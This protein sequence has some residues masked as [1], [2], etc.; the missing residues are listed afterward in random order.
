VPLDPVVLSQFRKR[1]HDAV[2][3]ANETWTM[4]RRL[5]L[6]EVAPRTIQQ[7]RAA[8]AQSQMDAGIRESLLSALLPGETAG[9]KGISGDLMRTITGLGATKAVRSLCVLVGLGAEEP[10]PADSSLSP[11]DIEAFLRATM[12]PYDLLLAVDRPSVI[13]FGAGDLMFEEQLVAQYLP[14]IKQTG[15]TLV[16]H[17]MDR[18]D[19]G[20]GS[21][22]VQ[23]EQDRLRR[24][25]QQ[26]S[27]HLRF[28]FSGNEDMFDLLA[29]QTGRRYTIA[30]CHSPASP[31]FAYEPS[32]LASKVID[33][34]LRET[35]G[36]FRRARRGG[37][38]V[39]EVHHGQEWLTFPPWKFD[40]YGPLALLDLLSRS[41]KLCVM[42]A[43]DMEVFLEILS[44]LLPD[45]S[46][47]PPDVFF[48]E[49]NAEKFFG[50]AFAKLSRLAVGERAVLDVIRPA[51]PRV[52]GPAGDRGETYS[53]R[54]VEVRRGA[55]FAEVPAGRTAY[56]F[57][58][59]TREAAPW[60]LTLVPSV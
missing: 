17:A 42:G 19:P 16:L 60:C 9:L 22:L 14:R 55:L 4:S 5:V 51:I 31:T 6:E 59:M 47:R 44:Q 53:F 43:V 7:L 57:D 29:S 46:A 34:H 38:D 52:L 39:L 37:K 21:E 35:K 28:R 12:N 36:E 32:R 33:R 15:K 30:V 40:V 41:G 8:L 49:Q 3:S 58:Q 18:L 23:A 20:Q 56:V 25:R 2:D 48:T 1:L 24:L 27:S 26:S 10:E 13:D 54:Y 11:P 50:S 45:D